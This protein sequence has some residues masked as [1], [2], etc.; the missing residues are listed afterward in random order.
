MVMSG[1]R[2]KTLLPGSLKVEPRSGYLISLFLHE[3]WSE[4]SR[5]VNHGRTKF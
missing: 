5:G 2:S 3:F 4:P 1:S